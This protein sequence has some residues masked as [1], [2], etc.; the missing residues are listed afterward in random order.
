ML[1]EHQWLPEFDDLPALIG[2]DDLHRNQSFWTIFDEDLSRLAN[3]VV[4]AFQRDLHKIALWIISDAE[5]LQPFR[6][7]PDRRTGVP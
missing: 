4:Q 1:R 7:P 6:M 2:A 3:E 5:Q